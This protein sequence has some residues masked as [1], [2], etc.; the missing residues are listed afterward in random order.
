[1]RHDIWPMVTLSHQSDPFPASDPVSRSSYILEMVRVGRWMCLVFGICYR[2]WYLFAKPPYRKDVSIFIIVLF[3]SSRKPVTRNYIGLVAQRLSAN[4]FLGIKVRKLE[5]TESWA[6]N[7]SGCCKWLD[8]AHTAPEDEAFPGL[9]EQ[10]VKASMAGPA[11]PCGWDGSH[12]L[13]Q[14]GPYQ[15]SI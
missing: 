2:L 8:E 10:Q 3:K 6:S 1:M 15:V 14:V 11:C 9:A 5:D 13:C 4:F 12:Y 7:D